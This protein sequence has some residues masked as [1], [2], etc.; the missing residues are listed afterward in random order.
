VLNWEKVLSIGATPYRF[1]KAKIEHL[2]SALRRDPDVGWFQVAVGDPLLV[3]S[4]QSLGNLT[5]VIQRL[6]DR[7]GTAKRFS[8]HQLENQA[9]HPF[10]F[11]QPIDGGNVG[12]V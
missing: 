7:Q 6:L 2:D 8:F 3:R 4:F 10:G 5:R 11:L 9:R 1:R 12:V